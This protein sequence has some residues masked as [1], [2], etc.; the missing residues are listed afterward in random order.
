MTSI[1]QKDLSLG[2]IVELCF[3]GY[4]TATVI[5]VDEHTVTLFR[6]YVHTSKTETTAGI[7]PYVGFEQFDLSRSNCL[8]CIRCS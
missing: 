2:D 4:N 5:K 6:P 8:S 1:E 7:T 3:D